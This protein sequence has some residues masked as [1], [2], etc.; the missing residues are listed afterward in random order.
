MELGRQR[1][2][3][4]ATQAFAVDVVDRGDGDVRELFRSLVIDLLLEG[5]KKAVPDLAICID[6]HAIHQNREL[7]KIRFGEEILIFEWNLIFY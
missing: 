3:Q 1:W 6:E 4:E 5:R 2:R 7:W